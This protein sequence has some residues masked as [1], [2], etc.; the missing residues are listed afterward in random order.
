MMKTVDEVKY[1][2]KDIYETSNDAK[3]L[4]NRLVT[5]YSEQQ[6]VTWYTF[7]DIVKDVVGYEVF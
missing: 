4:R 3:V 7:K 5:L 1:L 6:V 2:V